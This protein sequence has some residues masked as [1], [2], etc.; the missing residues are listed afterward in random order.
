MH[1]SRKIRSGKKEEPQSTPAPAEEKAEIKEE[2]KNESNKHTSYRKKPKEETNFETPKKATVNTKKT[3]E[4]EKPKPKE[5][6]K[7][8]ENVK[9][10]L[11][12][13][14]QKKKDNDGKNNSGQMTK[15]E[16]NNI[17]NSVEKYNAKLFLKGN[18]MEVYEEIMKENEEFKKDVFFKNLNYTEKKIGDMDRNKI[19]HNFKDFKFADIYERPPISGID[20]INKYY[21]KAEN[22]EEDKN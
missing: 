4:K 5:E 19:S 10:N 9:K 20:L 7:E 8:D 21:Q 13:T 16:F 17:L 2:P 18:L 15:E 3:E 11:F 14:P 22:I 12:E 1:R 6:K